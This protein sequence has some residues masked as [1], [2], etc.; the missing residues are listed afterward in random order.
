MEAS[1]SRSRQLASTALAALASL[2]VA[3]SAI[4]VYADREV[5]APGDFAD[6]AVASLD[7]PAVSN[8][9]GRIIAEAIVA[10]VNS[11]LIAFQALIQATA[12]GIVETQAFKSTLRAG[13][14][15]A[16]DIAFG[17]GD[18]GAIVTVANIGFVARS[19][20]ED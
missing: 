7:D 16:Y 11:D 5:L 18:D 15:E 12:T 1:G 13:L 8:A 17:Q 2:L 3:G 9:A 19:A 14:V 4:V 20:L 10:N 6:R